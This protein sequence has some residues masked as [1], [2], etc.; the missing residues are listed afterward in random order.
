MSD[1]FFMLGQPISALERQ[2]VSDYLRALDIAEDFPVAGLSDWRGAH[3]IITNPD[4]DRRCWGAERRETRRLKTKAAS[5]C[6]EV[7]MWESLSATTDDSNAAHGAAAV[8]AARLGCTD[9]GFIGAAAGAASE[10][11]YQAELARLAEEPEQHPF[12]L[13]QALFSA[14]HWPLGVA[15]GRY[16]IL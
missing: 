9:V 8:A 4:W 5:A 16:Y 10:A 11:A 3:Q 13:K 12:H 2:Q 14:G 7:R 6:G 1:W 15:N